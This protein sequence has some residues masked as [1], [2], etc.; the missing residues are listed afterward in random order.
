M[1]LKVNAD[2]FNKELMAEVG[3]LDQDFVNFR[4]DVI[5]D[6]LQVA[7]SRTPKG[8]SGD[9]VESWGA[10]PGKLAFGFGGKSGEFRATGS[11]AVR[12]FLRGTKPAES[13]TMGNDDFKASWFEF[14]TKQRRKKG[15]G[16]RKKPRGANT[17]RIT[18]RHMLAVG[19][20][21]V[22]DREQK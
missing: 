12:G 16:S 2:E 3:A 20:E 7:E 5:A 1:G 14:G 18:A 8:R 17:G 9:L 13:I 22:K 19:I 4:A 15:W 10:Q 6:A 11:Q 21:S